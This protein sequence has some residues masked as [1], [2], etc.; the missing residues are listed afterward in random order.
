MRFQTKR[1]FQRTSTKI[2]KL[3]LSAI[4]NCLHS[5]KTEQTMSV[6]GKNLF[7][8]LTGKTLDDMTRSNADKQ[9]KTDG[10]TLRDC[11]WTFLTQT[12]TRPALLLTIESLLSSHHPPTLK[13]P[14]WRLD[15]FISSAHSSFQ[16]EKFS[17]CQTAVKIKLTK[18][19]N[20][21]LRWNSPVEHRVHRSSWD[22][23]RFPPVG[24]G[25][26]FLPL[27]NQNYVQESCDFCN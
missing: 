5:E 24:L 12:G 17:S 1:F 13:A 25:V 11:C 4:E 16:T 18:F 3:F 27:K 8:K 19:G 20:F 7:F 2:E 22:E 10:T 9:S 14:V 15:S 23:A 26:F 6:G 21:F